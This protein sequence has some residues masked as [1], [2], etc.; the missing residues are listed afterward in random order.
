MSLLHRYFDMQIRQQT[1]APAVARFR[2]NRIT[3]SIQVFQHNCVAPCRWYGPLPTR[4][5]MS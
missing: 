4:K 1:T 2:R 3:R 5:M